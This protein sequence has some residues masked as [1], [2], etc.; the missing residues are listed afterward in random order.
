VGQIDGQGV[1]RAGVY[2]N[3]RLI[4]RIP[5]TASAGFQPFDQP[6]VL[7]SGSVVTVRAYS[8]GSV[9]IEQPVDLTG[10]ETVASAPSMTAAYAP[11]TVH[12]AAPGVA[13]QI[14]DVHPLAGNLYAVSGTVAGADLASAGLYQNGVL[15]QA[16]SVS[17]GGVASHGIGLS[18]GGILGGLMPGGAARSVAFTGTFNPA[19]GPV[20]I[21]AYNRAGSYTEQPVPPL[22][23]NG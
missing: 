10:N 7:S 2:A 1:T 8:V 14:T 16:I 3:G 9:Y 12:S 18:L 22:P 5:V 23:A 6:F 20:T 19:M 17:G 11:I 21:R 13:V 15:A 4:Q